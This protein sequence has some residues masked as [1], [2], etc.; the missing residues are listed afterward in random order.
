MN[1]KKRKKKEAKLSVFE[2][3]SDLKIGTVPLWKTVWNQSQTTFSLI[4]HLLGDPALSC[5]GASPAVKTARVSP[6]SLPSQ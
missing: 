5:R 1:V 2:A 4:A 3:A 6:S